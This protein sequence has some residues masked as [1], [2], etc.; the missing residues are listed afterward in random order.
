MVPTARSVEAMLVILDSTY[1]VQ[2]YTLQPNF[3]HQLSSPDL[4]ILPFAV[5]LRCC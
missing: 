5:A 3:P 4:R 2:P 1:A